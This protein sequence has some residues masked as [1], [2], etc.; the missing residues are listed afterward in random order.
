[1][2]G[3]GQKTGRWL[4]PFPAGCTYCTRHKSYLVLVNS[5][6][7]KPD[8]DHHP[9]QRLPSNYCVA[10]WL[11]FLSKGHSEE[12]WPIMPINGEILVAGT[13][14]LPPS[15]GL[16]LQ[17]LLDSQAVCFSGSSLLA[18]HL[19]A[20]WP[21][22]LLQPLP[23]RILYACHCHFLSASFLLPFFLFWAQDTE[24]DTSYSCPWLFLIKNP[25][26]AFLHFLSSYLPSYSE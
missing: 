18:S 23:L 12:F 5:R 21:S 10:T 15:L 17:S 16:S 2:V 8:S 26:L 9:R 6:K 14:C 19:L 24:S 25:N 3:G 22:P 11:S 7:F 1:M 20:A 4:A 13:G